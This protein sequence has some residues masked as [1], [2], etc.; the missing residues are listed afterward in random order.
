MKYFRAKSS[1][2]RYVDYNAS[3]SKKYIRE[4]SDAQKVTKTNELGCV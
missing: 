2:E 4:I 1:I 3:L